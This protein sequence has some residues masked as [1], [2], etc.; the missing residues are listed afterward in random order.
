MCTYICGLFLPDLI[1]IKMKAE[2][3]F[4]VLIGAV[5]IS[6]STVPTAVRFLLI[7]WSTK[8]GWPIRAHCLY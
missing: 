1:Y 4:S 5:V 6:T 7:V 2:C 3:L 8:V